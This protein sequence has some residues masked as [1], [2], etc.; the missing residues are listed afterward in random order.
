VESGAWTPQPIAFAELP[1]RF[2]YRLRP[3]P[4]RA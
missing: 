1:A 4:S 3:Q 2:G